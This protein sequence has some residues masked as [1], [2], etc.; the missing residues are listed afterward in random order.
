[1]VNYPILLVSN[2]PITRE[3]DSLLMLVMPVIMGRSDMLKLFLNAGHL[4]N[5]NISL[6]PT[7]P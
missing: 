3:G 1:M 4:Y 5:Y 7:P 6:I 2:T